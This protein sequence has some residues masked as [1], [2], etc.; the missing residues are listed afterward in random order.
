MTD[1]LLLL[2]QVDVVK[3]NWDYVK[4]FQKQNGQLPLAI[5][6][7]EAGKQIGPIG[8]QA[9]VDPNGGWYRHGYLVIH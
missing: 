9:P 1:A 3:A 4:T 2:G 5:L 8:F 7:E 6:P